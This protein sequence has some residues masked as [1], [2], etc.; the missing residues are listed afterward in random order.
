MAPS[1]I[2]GETEIKHSGERIERR[3]HGREFM[4]RTVSDRLGMFLTFASNALKVILGTKIESLKKKKS[5]WLFLCVD[6]AY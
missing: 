5:Q 2:K 1:Y 6:K 4:G 3:S